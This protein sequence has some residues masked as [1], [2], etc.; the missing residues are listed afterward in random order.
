MN[1][2]AQ[3]YQASQC[4]N[5]P[6]GNYGAN[7]LG[8]QMPPNDT[9]NPA[10]PYSHSVPNYSSSVPS[11]GNFTGQAVPASP[12][13]G[14][15]MYCA[16]DGHHSTPM[17]Q[18]APV[19]QNSNF[20]NPTQPVM[21]TSCQPMVNSP[22]SC[23]MGYSGSPMPMVNTPNPAHCQQGH[24]GSMPSPAQ[25]YVG[26]ATP[27]GNHPV[28]CHPMPSPAQASSG[29]MGPSMP[30]SPASCYGAGGQ[31]PQQLSQQPLTSP[32]AAA[33]AP[34][35]PSNCWQQNVP[36]MQAAQMT[37]GSNTYPNSSGSNYPIPGPHDSA[38]NQY[39]GCYYQHSHHV[40]PCANCSHQAYHQA[41]HAPNCSPGWNNYNPQVPPPPYQQ[42]PHHQCPQPPIPCN[43]SNVGLMAPPAPTCNPQS[44]PPSNSGHS[45]H[46]MSYHSLGN[47]NN[48]TEIQCRDISQSSPNTGNNMTPMNS[49]RGM[50][51]EVYQR[52]LEY[53][54]QCQSWAGS[55]MVSSTTHPFGTGHE[56]SAPKGPVSGST[57]N[58]VINDMTSSLTSLLE[59]NRYLQMIQ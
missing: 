56:A 38:T 35:P 12:A 5:Y 11:N 37:R 50:R 27:A 15:A 31:S 34:Q 1:N 45:I 23:H 55:D 19:Q 46:N 44:R 21:N 13:S 48:M 14:S 10:A 58:M 49:A 17:P 18:S 26:P 6:Q 9:T 29:Y 7:Y 39:G 30:T 53:V 20:N 43:N 22:G 33:P 28:H 3:T 57:S 59:E 32:A 4:N 51:Q 24:C 2:S 16:G 25:G 41:S 36:M 40:G 8:R 47:N 42:R 52:T 54:Q